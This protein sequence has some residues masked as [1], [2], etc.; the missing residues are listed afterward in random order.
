MSLLQ[1]I[2]APFFKLQYLI[3]YLHILATKTENE[4]FLKINEN[5]QLQD[6]DFQIKYDKKISKEK[7]SENWH[8]Q[9]NFEVN[10]NCFSMWFH[11]E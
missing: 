9:Q 6:T 2:F 4:S 7:L 10:G 1:C 5:L 8:P 11:F 3:I